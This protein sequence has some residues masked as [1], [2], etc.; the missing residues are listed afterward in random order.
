MQSQSILKLITP[1]NYENPL[2][3]VILD[4]YFGEL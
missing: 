4:D 2:Y 3:P 1:F